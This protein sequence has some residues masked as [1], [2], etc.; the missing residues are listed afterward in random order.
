MALITMP[1]YWTRNTSDALVSRWSGRS[2]VTPKRRTYD[3]RDWCRNEL[4]AHFENWYLFVYYQNHECWEVLFAL[5]GPTKRSVW[6][7]DETYK[8][9]N[10]WVYFRVTIIILQIYMP[11]QTSCVNKL[12]VQNRAKILGLNW[13]LLFLL[14]SSNSNKKALWSHD[15]VV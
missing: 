4:Y 12:T 13:Q 10:T 14:L 7:K 9:R 1:L 6:Y 11:N 2:R 8:N 3:Q 15:G 5:F